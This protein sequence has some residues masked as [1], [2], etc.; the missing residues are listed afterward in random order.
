MG[1]ATIESTVVTP[2]N[3]QLKW[4]DSEAVEHIEILE[5]SV[6]NEK[7]V[8]Y[9]WGAASANIETINLGA[10]VTAKVLLIEVSL[11]TLTVVPG[12]VGSG[13]HINVGGSCL[14]FDTAITGLVVGHAASVA[15]KIIILGDA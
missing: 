9:D 5:G 4:V 8:E 3:P 10:I 15:A 1:V 2:F 12:G 6:N 11:G 13:F 7:S 14:L